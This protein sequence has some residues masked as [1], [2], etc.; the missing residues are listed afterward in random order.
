MNNF[1]CKKIGFLYFLFSSFFL[2]GAYGQDNELKKSMESGKKL[3]DLK[4]VSCHMNSGEG[5]V[6]AF[7]PLANSDYLK[8]DIGRAAKIIISGA[9]G[10]MVVNGMAYYGVMQ[11]NEM[12]NKEVSDVLNYIRNSWGNKGEIINEKTIESIR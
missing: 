6:G 4:C 9:S 1:K 8:E 3:Y 11:G 2:L 7:P 12:T 10:K 5:I